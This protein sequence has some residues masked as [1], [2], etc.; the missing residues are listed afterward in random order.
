V[1]PGNAVSGPGPFRV[2]GT[3]N[4]LV[5]RSLIV[6]GNNNE[7]RGTNICVVGRDATV[8][9]QGQDIDVQWGDGCQTRSCP[10]LSCG[11]GRTLSVCLDGECL[12]GCV[13]R[14]TG[15]TGQTYGYGILPDGRFSAQL[16][17][18]SFVVR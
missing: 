5:G 6:E 14:G 2:N 13:G 4:T 17:S 12:N 16:G 8:R 1:D 15:K 11:N 18:N 10:P 7:V 3:G 9:T